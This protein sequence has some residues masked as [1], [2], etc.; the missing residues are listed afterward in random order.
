MLVTEIGEWV[1][2]NVGYL[3]QKGKY[4]WDVDDG[5]KGYGFYP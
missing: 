2:F 4:Y 5:G 1:K 3:W